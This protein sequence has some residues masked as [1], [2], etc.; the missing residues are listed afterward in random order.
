MNLKEAQIYLN[1]NDYSELASLVDEEVF[2]IKKYFFTTAFHPKLAQSKVQKLNKL[3]D[4]QNNALQMEPKEAMTLI[5]ESEEISSFKDCSPLGCIVQYNQKRSELLIQ[6]HRAE[7]IID[8]IRCIQSKTI[9]F[10]NFASKWPTLNADF[11]ELKLT[12]EIDPI[13]FLQQ[14]RLLDENGIN[15]FESLAGNQKLISSDLIHEFNRL[16]KIALEFDLG[17]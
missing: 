16:N 14:L 12:K 15:S 3:L 2:R 1:A 10:L 4:I 13:I 11:M 17:R 9:L 6:L 7:N 8:I 5:L